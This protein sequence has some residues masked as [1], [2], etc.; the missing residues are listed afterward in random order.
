[1]GTGEAGEMQQ[2][3]DVRRYGAAGNG[4]ADDTAA[5]QAAIDAAGR[6]GGGVVF[7]PASSAFYRLSHG[8]IGRDGVTVRGEGRG[9]FLR[10]TRTPDI[11]DSTDVPSSRR[12][13][14]AQSWP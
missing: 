2:T 6:A 10:N 9:S 3:F 8:L 12:T 13:R 4:R 14:T 11:R 7:V 1:M 5:I